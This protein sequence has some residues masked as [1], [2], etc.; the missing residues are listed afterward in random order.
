MLADVLYDIAMWRLDENDPSSASP[1]ISMA[2]E[3]MP[4]DLQFSQLNREVDAMLESQGSG[5]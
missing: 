3:L 5:K 4:R 2:A 1:A